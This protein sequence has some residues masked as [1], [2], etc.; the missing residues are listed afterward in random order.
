MATRR[1]ELMR[2]DASALV[3]AAYVVPDL[4]VAVQEGAF[5]WG[6]GGTRSILKGTEP[7]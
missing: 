7:R 4:V 3:A 5:V 1:V 2:E 6:W